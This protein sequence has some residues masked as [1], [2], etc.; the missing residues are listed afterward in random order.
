[1]DIYPEITHHLLTSGDNRSITINEGNVGS[2]MNYFLAGEQLMNCI[3][4]IISKVDTITFYGDEKN[5][6]VLTPTN[7]MMRIQVR[8]SS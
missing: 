8:I 6:N 4:N 3:G 5:P 2:I 1:M 7:G